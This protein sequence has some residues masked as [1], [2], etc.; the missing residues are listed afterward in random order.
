MKEHRARVFQNG[1]QRS[2]FG[3]E[4]EEVIGEWRKFHN[5]ELHILYSS[6]DV[7]KVMK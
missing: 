4:R 3:T 7:I 5:G 1:V 2:I 6:P